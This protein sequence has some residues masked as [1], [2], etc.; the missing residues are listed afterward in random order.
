MTTGAALVV[1]SVALTAPAAR[2]A[3][4]LLHPRVLTI[5]MAVAVLSAGLPY[6]LELVALRTVPASTFSILLSLEPA[7][8]ALMGLAILRQHLGPAE[9]LAVLLVVIASAG[10]SRQVGK[11]GTAHAASPS[12]SRDLPTAA[13]SV[14]PATA[15]SPTGSHDRLSRRRAG[16][17]PFATR[18]ICAHR[19][20]TAARRDPVMAGS[21]DQCGNQGMTGWGH[22]APNGSYGAGSALQRSRPGR[23]TESAG[24]MWIVLLDLLPCLRPC[25]RG[26]G[27]VGA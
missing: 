24:R 22:P 20:V 10:A 15:T 7:A 6:L 14:A 8:G 26:F 25:F 18:P 17:I 19:A 13:R 5:A 2:A 23:G 3:A 9:L 12:P 1:S 21:A 4:P 27:L 16:Q 11:P